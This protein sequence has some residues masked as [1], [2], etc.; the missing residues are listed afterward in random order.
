LPAQ[1]PTEV[2]ISLQ[3]SE[4]RVLSLTPGVQEGAAPGKIVQER[5]KL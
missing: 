4:T 2:Q 1:P 5:Q 3:P